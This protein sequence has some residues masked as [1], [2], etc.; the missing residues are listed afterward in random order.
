MRKYAYTLLTLIITIAI[1]LSMIPTRSVSAYTEGVI[2]AMGYE[3]EY[4][5]SDSYFAQPSSEYLNPLADVSLI[6]SMTS[7]DEETAHTFYGALG[8]KA[9]EFNQGFKDT[10]YSDKIGLVAASKDIK[11]NGETCSLVVLNVRG[12]N[13]GIEW[14]DNFNV[15]DSGNHL[16]FD[17]NAQ[18][19]YEF[20]KSY[21]DDNGL[22]NKHVKVWIHGYSRG[23]AISYMTT[24]LVFDSGLIKDQNDLYCY[25]FNAPNGVIDTWDDCTCVFNI[26]NDM[27]IVQRTAPSI[28]GFHKY[29]KIITLG[30]PK[31]VNSIP[32][33]DLSGDVMLYP[34]ED[35]YV[36]KMDLKAAFDDGG[37]F[38]SKN[39]VQYDVM[40]FYDKF[41]Q[42]ISDDT[43]D[44]VVNDK[45][46]WDGLDE[47]P[48]VKDRETYFKHYQTG[49]M[50]LFEISFSG[51]N[52]E[53]GGILDFSSFLAD[54]I[55][56]CYDTDQLYPKTIS[57]IKDSI[58]SRDPSF[59]IDEA[60]LRSFIILLGKL[61]R[62]DSGAMSP[63]GMAFADFT[64]MATFLGNLNYIVRGHYYDVLLA[65]IRNNDQQEYYE[66]DVDFMDLSS[67]D[68]KLSGES[69]KKPGSSYEISCEFDDEAYVFLGWYDA[70]GKLIT[71]DPTYSFPAYQNESFKAS[72]EEIVP[73]EPE[74]TSSD[75]VD[76]DDKEENEVDRSD[77]REKSSD[78]DYTVPIIIGIVGAFVLGGA[79]GATLILLKRKRK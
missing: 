49:I 73:E 66:I 70:N 4:K 54:F 13:Y 52:S 24:K 15:G 28:W 53:S 23:G 9:F 5:F 42:F 10:D 20:L 36:R 63:L 41:F 3:F 44:D 38:A 30:D 6:A 31:T 51:G 59:K 67:D 11:I 37:I 14:A 16:G 7:C 17:T 78:T 40:T 39:D 56:E 21:I 12:V 64:M 71:E 32:N 77:K 75:S 50:Y 45:R 29:G 27:D 57:D 62:N 35:F 79:T 61:F 2:D 65:W 58:E 25:T 26:V 47:I 18:R 34:A 60:R 55:S 69:I 68:I 19:A 76:S 74:E 33:P 22:S 1:T 8:F 48:A 72:F 43:I 46:A